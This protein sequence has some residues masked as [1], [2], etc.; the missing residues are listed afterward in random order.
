MKYL[1]CPN[2]RLSES[3][4]LCLETDDMR[5]TPMALP[6]DVLESFFDLEEQQK[7]SSQTGASVADF[8]NVECMPL[9]PSE[10]VEKCKSSRELD[11]VWVILATFCVGLRDTSTEK[12]VYK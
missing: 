8:G 5:A 1:F 12:K 6:E 3:K 10:V 11:H 4:F 9:N 2:I 7:N